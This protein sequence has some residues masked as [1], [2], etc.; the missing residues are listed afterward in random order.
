MGVR[1]LADLI[2]AEM[3]FLKCPSSTFEEI[4]KGTDA[5]LKYLHRNR[6]KFPPA[7]FEYLSADWHYDFRDHRCPHDSLVVA[8]SVLF[9]PSIEN[10]GI[11]SVS[12]SLI[13]AYQDWG[14]EFIYRD[15]K[16]LDISPELSGWS[17]DEVVLCP[18]GMRH[19]IAF[20]EGTAWIIEAASIEVEVRPTRAKP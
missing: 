11:E 2:D 6:H 3:K 9:N 8:Y 18:N 7:L 16:S 20:D 5:Y 15:V 19:E 17:H 4:G 1:P 13:N 10:R 12:I 14:I